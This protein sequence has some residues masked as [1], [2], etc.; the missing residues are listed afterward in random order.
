MERMGW[1]W[2]SEQGC[3]GGYGRLE[4]SLKEVVCLLIEDHNIREYGEG[5]KDFI[6][7]I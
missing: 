4:R 6:E 2:V 5:K 7:L 3:E 1:G